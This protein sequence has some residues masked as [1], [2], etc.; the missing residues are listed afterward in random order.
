MVLSSGE[1][2]KQVR[3]CESVY[4]CI[5]GDWMEG[6]FELKTELHC[7]LYSTYYTH[8]KGARARDLRTWEHSHG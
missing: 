7:L 8:E 6:G 3:A 1:K 2:V 5:K 4:V